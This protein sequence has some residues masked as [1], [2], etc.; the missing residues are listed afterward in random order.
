MCT[1][2]ARQHPSPFT[3]M[4]S[5]FFRTEQPSDSDLGP[6]WECIENLNDWLIVLDTVDNEIFKVAPLNAKL[7]AHFSANTQIA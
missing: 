7:A 5:V 2:F 1:S 6:I 4:F 3:L